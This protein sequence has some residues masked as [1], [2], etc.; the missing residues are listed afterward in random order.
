M[1]DLGAGRFEREVWGGIAAD[2]VSDI[3]FLGHDIM[4]WA[5]ELYR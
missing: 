5:F 1:T 4:M 2:D 3:G